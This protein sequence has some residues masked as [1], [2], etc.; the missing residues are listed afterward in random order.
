MLA[1]RGCAGRM[2]GPCFALVAALVPG[3]VAAWAPE[4]PIELIVPTAAGG[5]L[6]QTMRAIDRLWRDLNM[7]NVPISVINRPGG[8]HA[9]AANSIHQSRGDAHRIVLLSSTLV[10]NPIMGRMKARYPDFTV[11]GQ[12]YT[13]YMVVSVNSASPVKSGEDL[14]SRLRKAPDALSVAV[15]SALG[16]ASHFGIAVPMKEAGVNIK[17]MRSVV[18]PAAQGMTN[19]LGG[20]VDV[21]TGPLTA[22]APHWRAG[23]LRILAVT[24]PE[25]LGGE[26]GTI[27]TWREQKVEGVDGIV[28]NPRILVAPPGLTQ[29]QVAFWD[30]L[31]GRMV[32]SREWLELV[33]KHQWINQYIPSRDMPRYLAAEEKVHRE[34]LT[35]LGLA[36]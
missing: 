7:V 14:V 17:A 3:A 33:E 36:K 28:T 15:G 10:S 23:K 31:L 20:H 30:D 35:E 29:E 6:D 25:R 24:A 11:L 9:I 19:V 21:A 18:F 27:P 16:T 13:E 12:I 34:I 5:G 32:K 26:F 4:K 8:G 22:A 2:W 1:L